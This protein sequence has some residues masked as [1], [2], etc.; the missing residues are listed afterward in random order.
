MSS[1]ENHQVATAD[2]RV[3]EVLT[4]GPDDGFPLV[5]HHGTPQAAVPYGILERPAAARGLRTIACSR[6]GYGRSTPRG[7]AGTT[8][9]VADD[10]L[11]TAAVLDHFGYDEFVTLGWSGG[12]PRALACAA[13]LPD[14]CRA[15]T[16]GVGI[17]PPDAAGLDLLAGMAPEN[18]AEYT[19]V[20][21]GSAALT[22]FLEEHGTPVFSVTADLIVLGLGDLLPEVD[23]AAL[24]GE[25][26]EYLAA[27][28][29][30][31]G[32]QG[33]VGWRD[34]D[35]THSRPWGFDLGRITVPVSVWQGTEDRMVPFAH[36]V[37]L[38]EHVAGA[39]AHLLEGEGHVS[40]VVQ[41]DRVIDDLLDLA[42]R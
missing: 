24:T 19:A 13:V 7:D 28:A 12:G 27:S 3:L 29:R 20:R 2:G 6:P 31:A 36:A 32:L 15:A 8:A 35:L 38:A 34:D 39:R 9:T 17:A 11:D 21:Q 4:A 14:R 42:G 23:K 33:I 18:V 1:S 40:L 16:C 26:A 30:R 5:F 41:M 22:A 37:W 10:A 25:L